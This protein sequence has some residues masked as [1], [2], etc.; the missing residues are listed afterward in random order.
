[1]SETAIDYIRKTFIDAIV[2]EQDMKIMQEIEKLNLARAHRPLNTDTNMYRKFVE[3]TNAK[4]AELKKQYPC[5]DWENYSAVETPE[6]A[7]TG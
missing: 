2:D 1:L 6:G 3:A 7:E 4:E 5:L